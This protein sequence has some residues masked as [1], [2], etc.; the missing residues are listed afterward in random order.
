[1]LTL[2]SSFTWL[3][4]SEHDRRKALEVVQCFAEK[5]T[6]DE[7]GIGTVR[8]AFSALLFPGTSI[9]H[10]RAR[11]LFFVPW[12]YRRL[13]KRRWG[14]AAEVAAQARRD[15][16]VLIHALA[17]S[18]DRNG[19]IGIEARETLKNLPSQLYWQGLRVLGLRLVEGG[20]ALVHR[21]LA[22]MPLRMPSML[23]TDDG[24]AIGGGPQ[25]FWHPGIPDSP[26]G[27]PKQAS[28]RLTAEEARFLQDRARERVGESLLAC[29]L[30]DGRG[31]REAELPWQYPR[32]GELRAD[33]REQLL[34]ARNFSE[35]MLGAALLYNLM[36]AERSEREDLTSRYQEKLDDWS[37]RVAERAEELAGWDR[38]AMWSLV[39]GVN[40]RVSMRTQSFINSWLDVAC[41]H[42]ASRTVA[43]N[44]EL[45]V[46]IEQRERVLKGALAKLSNRRALEQWGGDSGTAQLSYRWGNVRQIVD[47]VYSA[48]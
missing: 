9:L 13:E 45:R 8:D 3:D 38:R 23:R 19:V 29:L 10:T 17:E 33:H 46:L 31:V 16:V 12:I 35:T 43:A 27:F 14:S 18:E 20:Q 48:L 44:K 41:D 1:M 30:S 36:L 47:D 7:L 5:G 4:Y 42:E 26:E 21:R 6:V 32:L 34:H 24:D 39:L 2:M 22:S 28:F 37:A 40:P 15:E 25:V 11:Y